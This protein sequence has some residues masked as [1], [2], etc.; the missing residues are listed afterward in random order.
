MRSSRSARL[1]PGGAKRPAP[2][3]SKL[4][5]AAAVFREALKE[6]ADLIGVDPT[7]VSLLLI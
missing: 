3:G 6:L 4:D 5:D 2:G 7:A 1:A